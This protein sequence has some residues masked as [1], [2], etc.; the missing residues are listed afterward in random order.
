MT[1]AARACAPTTAMSVVSV[2]LHVRTAD[3]LKD[4][5]QVLILGPSMTKLLFLRYLEKSVPA[6][7]AQVVGLETAE[8]PG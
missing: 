8:H 2:P 6:L 1:V 3:T 5:D 4:A 7:G